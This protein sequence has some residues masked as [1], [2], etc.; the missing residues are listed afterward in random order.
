MMNHQ[1]GMTFSLFLSD[2]ENGEWRPSLCLRFVLGFGLSHHPDRIISRL[3][4]LF[5]NSFPAVKDRPD[6]RAVISSVV[7]GE[8]LDPLPH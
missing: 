4:L 7:W 8:I 5:Y 3:N 2:K 1:C 6:F